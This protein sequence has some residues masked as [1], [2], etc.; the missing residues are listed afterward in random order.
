MKIRVTFPRKRCVFPFS[1]FPTFP[2]AFLEKRSSFPL[3]PKEINVALCFLCRVNRVKIT[4]FSRLARKL[5][6]HRENQTLCRALASACTVAMPW[7][8][9]FITSAAFRGDA[10]DW[11]ASES[12]TRFDRDEIRS[13]V[14]GYKSSCCFSLFISLH[15]ARYLSRSYHSTGVPCLG[16]RD[17][18]LRDNLHRRQIFQRFISQPQKL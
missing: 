17:F 7:K 18:Q 3:F 15:N 13:D 4:L 2:R 16:F 5:A 11:R 14:P 8:S 1:A 6:L 10:A 12:F 9:S